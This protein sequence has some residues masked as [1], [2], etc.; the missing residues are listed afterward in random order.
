MMGQ[1][2]KVKAHE[3]RPSVQ[4][5]PTVDNGSPVGGRGRP[6]GLG[7]PETRTKPSY[8]YN[9]RADREVEEES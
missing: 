4:Q 7:M 5:Q 8:R 6:E 2:Q 9:T 3:L 1:G